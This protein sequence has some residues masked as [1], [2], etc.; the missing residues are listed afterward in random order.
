MIIRK[1][2]IYNVL[3]SQTSFGKNTYAYDV[4]LRFFESLYGGI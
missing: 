1:L 2:H 4:I 3:Y